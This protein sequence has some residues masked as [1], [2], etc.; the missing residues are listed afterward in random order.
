MYAWQQED[1]PPN[2]MPA[3]RGVYVVNFLQGTELSVTAS[4]GSAWVLSM[5]QMHGTL[6]AVCWSVLIVAAVGKRAPPHPER[7]SLGGRV[8][9]GAYLCLCTHVPV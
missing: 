4:G 3:V 1:Q 8:E 5:Q 2:A 6:M 7:W 9:L